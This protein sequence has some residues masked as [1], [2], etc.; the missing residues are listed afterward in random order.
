[1]KAFRIP[2]STY[3][4][5]ELEPA[6]Q[7]KGVKLRK[8]WRSVG[9]GVNSFVLPLGAVI[10]SIDGAPLEAVDFKQAVAMIRKSTSRFIQVQ[11]ICSEDSENVNPN[12]QVR[13]PSPVGCTAL[14][15]GG[16]RKMSGVP[17]KVA[18]SSS[19]KRVLSSKAVGVPSTSVADAKTTSHSTDELESVKTLYLSSVQQVQEKQKEVDDLSK[20]VSELKCQTRGLDGQIVLLKYQLGRRR[21]GGDI[22]VHHRTTDAVPDVHYWILHWRMTQLVLATLRGRFSS[23]EQE[24][25]TDHAPITNCEDRNVATSDLV[26]QLQTKLAV[27]EKFAKR[28]QLHIHG[29]VDVEIMK[30]RHAAEESATKGISSARSTTSTPLAHVY[31]SEK[32][33]TT[34]PRMLK[35]MF[36]GFV[37]QNSAS[38]LTAECHET[39]NQSVREEPAI[40]ASIDAKPQSLTATL[41]LSTPKA[42]RQPA[43]LSSSEICSAWKAWGA[44]RY[45]EVASVAT[46]NPLNVVFSPPSSSPGTF[47]DQMSR[48]RNDH[49]KIREDIRDFRLNLKVRFRF[50]RQARLC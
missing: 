22:R 34:T 39:K 16:Q 29:L 7:G 13:G 30:S 19:P 9:E 37:G 6:K 28:L 11:C 35:Q 18:S 38:S 10:C 4:G 24:K 33:C 41:D 49:V 20:E 8:E 36:D 1:M 50:W 42:P 43:T 15:S 40:L 46:V 21:T 45:T 5:L 2:C 27:E 12:P 23:P 14:V 32:S 25:S 17:N 3:L 31:I 48:L 47:H 26:K 44:R